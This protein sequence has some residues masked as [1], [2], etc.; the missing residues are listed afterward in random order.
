[1]T[2]RN[3]IV[4]GER[5]GKLTVLER[6]TPHGAKRPR[7]RV[8]CDCGDEYTIS[9]N[10]FRVAMSCKRCCP[11]GQPRKYGTDRVVQGSK[12]YTT[13]IGMRRRC[14]ATDDP[15]CAHWAG[16]GI[17]VCQEWEE[18]FV[19]F[20]RWA[21]AN[22]YHEGLSIDRIDV[23]GNY[24]PGNCQWIT[25]SANSKKARAAYTPV[26]KRPGIFADYLPIE[27]LFGHC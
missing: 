12:L 2:R 3:A 15:R 14:R 7:Y 20:E 21:L 16:R 25:R 13:W 1:M 4:V 9:G 18:S 23:D 17:K 10:T 11:R 24:E 27:A 6:E 19:A 26:R 8:K 22:D 5:R